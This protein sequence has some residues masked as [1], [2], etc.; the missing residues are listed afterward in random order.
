MKALPKIIQG[1]MGVAVSNWKMAR[2]VSL[3]GQ[4]GVVSGT[5]I[6]NVLARRLQLGDSSG[7]MR[8]GIAAFP[9][10][11]M[12]KAILDRYFIEG[13]KEPEVPFL[14][15]P[16]LTLHQSHF[17]RE[18][19]VVSTFV[20]VWLAKEGHQGL[21]GINF[22]EKI[23]MAN[24]A[25]ILGAMLAGVDY[26]L[27]GAGLPREIPNFIKEIS[28]GRTASLTIAIKNGTDPF[29]IAINPL[30]FSP[31]SSFPIRR[32]DFLAI[33]SSDVLATYLS[34]EEITKPNGFIIESSIAGGHNAPPRGKLVFDENNEP[35]YGPRDQPDLAKI[36]A[37]GLPFWLA[38]GFGNP[39]QLTA[40]LKAGAA[41]IQ[42]GTLF[43]LCNESGFTQELRA[44]V[45]HQL[46]SGELEIR[47][48]SLA[49][50]TSF[51]I[52]IVNVKDSASESNVYDER[53]K[54]CDLGYLRTPVQFKSGHIGY[55]CPGE[56]DKAFVKKG[57]TAEELI[58]RKC[59][60]NGL[61]SSVGMPQH[62]LSGYV[63]PTLLTLG[64]DVVGL[65]EL[66]SRYQNGWGVRETIAYLLGI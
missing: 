17:S 63:E 22:L 36:K 18:L 43:A 47:T 5:A 54:L 26:I 13:G 38:G 10:Q 29:S 34:R 57:G 62:R 39:Q 3:C 27:M 9:N 55:R 21:V 48:D 51:P 24:G 14:V 16:K 28:L 37:L 7:D 41:G 23:Q 61:M 30:D 33:I 32:P 53:A 8:R 19:L 44:Q 40:A 15:A 35:I 6:D 45:L 1:G 66:H 20:E 49:S 4:L 25:S 2:E 58:G 46:D 31:Q 52:K 50:P 60:C 64:S 42:V 11:R 59:I 12:A 56:P 65:R